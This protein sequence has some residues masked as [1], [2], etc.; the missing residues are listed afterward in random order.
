[1]VNNKRRT[2]I[3]LS[4]FFLLISTLIHR[5]EICCMF[6]GTRYYGWPNAFVTVSKTTEF[7][8]EAKKIETENIFYLIKNGWKVNFAANAMGQYGISSSAGFNLTTNYL[9]Y[10]GVSHLLIKRCFYKK[11]EKNN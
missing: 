11:Y 3:I 2:V 7:L 9:I 10:L 1:M 8:D 5:S 4:V 6:N